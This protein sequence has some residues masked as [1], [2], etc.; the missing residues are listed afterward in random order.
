MDIILGV[1]SIASGAFAF[2]CW[3]N[4]NNGKGG[5]LCS[6]RKRSMVVLTIIGFFS[7]IVLLNMAFGNT[8]LEAVQSTVNDLYLVFLGSFLAFVFH[9]KILG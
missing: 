9:N 2:M 1:L 8:A 5:P 4:Y 7:S 6:F 3:R